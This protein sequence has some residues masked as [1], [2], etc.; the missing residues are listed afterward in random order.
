LAKAVEP[1]Q[2]TGVD[3]SE[4]EIKRA[5]ERAFKEGIKN[6]R[7]EIGDS[8]QLGLSDS[9]FDAVFSHNV[10]EHIAEPISAL[11]EMRRVLKPGGVIGVRDVDLGGFLFAPDKGMLERAIIVFSE[12]WKYSGGDPRIGR[13]LGE[14]FYDAGFVEVKVSAS[15][16]YYNDPDGCRLIAQSY[17][18]AF[19]EDRH[20]EY[21]I[22]NGLANKEELESM[23]EAY[24]IWC[25][26]PGAFHAR[27]HCEAIGWKA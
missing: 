27:S 25:E 1:G 24:H 5:R 23:N 7:F 26:L 12:S 16:E 2:V 15:Y 10:L 18:S 4:T 6:V 9:S 14:L 20:V 22:A 19:S 17:T 21:A 8:C 11:K 3:I 13:R